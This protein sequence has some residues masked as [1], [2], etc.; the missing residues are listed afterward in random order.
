MRIL[1]RSATALAVLIAALAGAG[2]AQAGFV[3][4]LGSPFPYAAP[5]QTL[6]V[7]DGDR[8]G[9]VDVA[10]GGLTLRRGAGSGFLGNPIA[11]GT[12]GPVEGLAS[13]DLNGDGLLDYAAIAPGVDPGDPRRLL[14]FLA[15]SGNGF[16][17]ETLLA[18]AD[19]ASALAAANVNGDG[20]P[21]IVLV[22]DGD[23]DPAPG[24]EAG[25]QDVTVLLGGLPIAGAEHYSSDIDGPTDVELGDLTGDGLPEI[26]VAGDEASVS[27]L[28][29]EGGGEFADGDLE[30]TG[31]SGASRRIALA[32]LDGGGRLDLLATDSGAAAL[33]VLLGD[34]D[35]GF[36]PR[37]PR[38][39]GLG[40]AAASV[41]AGDM[42]GDGATDALAGGSGGRFAVLLGSGGGGL[43]PAPGS[44]FSSGVA[45]GDRIDDLVAADMNRDGQVDVVTANRGGS[46]SVQLNDDTG[47]LSATPSAANFGALLPASGLGAQTITLRANRGRLRVTRLD[48]QGSR[49]FT[50]RDG[51]CLGRTLLLGQACTLSVTFNAPRKARRYEALLSVDANAAAVVVPL[52]ATTRAPIVR[53]A[54][55]KHKRVAP[56]ERLDLRYA[57]SEGALT[58]VL[59]ERALP[60]RRVGGRCVLPRRGNLQRR[61][62]TIWQRVATVTRRDLA[63]RNRMRV[64]TRAK[65]EGFGRKRRPGAAYA[66][67]TY[68]LGV[69]AV[70]RFRNRSAER[71][72]RFK[73]L[74]P[75]G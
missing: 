4:A 26:V 66:V 20:L 11:V 27:V 69:S 35:G 49:V 21:D 68:R 39:T 38:A 32:Q 16:V 31:A 51:D 75:R 42:N 23:A 1:Y 5:T 41:A 9:T 56:G 63:G 22:R 72:V 17:Q 52:T 60:G 73:V 45:A 19:D 3:P 33:L 70:D 29:N 8:N 12:T 58:R 10:A 59:T 54:R 65:P 71:R 24:G 55:L 37:G 30:P 14:R 48:R 36:Q 67:G 25:I 74:R 47:L 44:P 15:T 28:V 50:V 18:D 40:G 7:A 64:P 46:V 61:T 62:C 53:S 2:T 34:G 6:A 43:A 57:L 13:G